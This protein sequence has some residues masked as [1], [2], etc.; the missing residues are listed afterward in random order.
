MDAGLGADRPAL[1][2][3]GFSAGDRMFVELGRVEIPVDRGEIFETEFVGAV[4][5]VP[6][7]RFLHGR[8]P[9][10]RPAA[11]GHSPG[12]RILQHG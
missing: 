9:L 12:C 1:D 3:I 2:D 11:A 10:K 8:P 7:T 4:G 6:Q 5:A